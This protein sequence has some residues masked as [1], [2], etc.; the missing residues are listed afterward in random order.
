MFVPR[1]LPRCPAARPPRS[2]NPEKLMRLKAQPPARMCE[3][4]VKRGF[5]V[6]LLVRPVHWLQKEV[7]ELMTVSWR[8]HP[9]LPVLPDLPA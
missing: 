4:V 1:R 7:D 6:G 3:A 5:G 9:V 2:W 8:I